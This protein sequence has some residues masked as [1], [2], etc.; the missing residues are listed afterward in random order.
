MVILMI[1]ALLHLPGHP[2]LLPQDIS[3][4]GLYHECICLLLLCNLM[5]EMSNVLLKYPSIAKK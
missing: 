3:I 1:I 2:L 5:G 4:Q